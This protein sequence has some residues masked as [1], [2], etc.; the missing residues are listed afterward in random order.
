MSWLYSLA[1][2]LREHL[3]LHF[4]PGMDWYNYGKKAGQWSIDHTR[5]ISRFPASATML[6]IN[7]LNNLRPM[8]HIENCSKRNKWE[9]Q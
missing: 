4:Q 3:E 8:W 5:P 1:L 9:G 6:E 7:A 2:Q